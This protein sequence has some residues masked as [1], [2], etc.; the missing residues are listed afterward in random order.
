M[1]STDIGIWLGALLTIFTY[2][3]FVKAQQNIFFRFAQSTVVGGSLGYIIAIVFFKNVDYL[4]VQ[5][6]IA[7]DVFYIIPLIIGALIYTRF[8]P[9]IS[10][11]ARIP[12][13]VIIAVGLGLGARSTMDLDLYQQT[14]G[15]YQWTLI[16]VDGLTAV[17]NIILLVG[18]ITVTAYFF[19]TIRK[20]KVAGL[21]YITTIGRYYLM[22]W[23]GAKFGNTVT[24]RFTLLIGRFQFLLYDWLGLV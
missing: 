4:G 21:G 7:G 17:N 6:L 12:I 23:F 8:I 13:A 19:F 14:L 2:S 18:V 1:I 5:K 24:A 10:Y 20:E 16:G 15:T 11:L 9:Q 3:Y 22:I